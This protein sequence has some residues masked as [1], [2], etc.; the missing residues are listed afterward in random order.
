MRIQRAYT[1]EVEYVDKLKEQ[2]INASELINNLLKDYFDKQDPANMTKE[3]IKKEIARIELKEEYE[4]RL[5]EL[6]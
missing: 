5:K 1:I 2:R 3:Q 6:G 4:K